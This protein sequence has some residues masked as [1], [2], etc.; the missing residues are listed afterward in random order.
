MTECW[1]SNGKLE[2]YLRPATLFGSNFEGY[3]TE[4]WERQEADWSSN[5]KDDYNYD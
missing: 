1:L 2:M 4:D 5:Y 3:L